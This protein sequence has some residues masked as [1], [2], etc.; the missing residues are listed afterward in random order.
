MATA[1]KRALLA[2]SLSLCSAIPSSGPERPFALDRR[3]VSSFGSQG[4]NLWMLH[5]NPLGEK[6]CGSGEQ[7]VFQGGKQ[8]PAHYFEQP[9]DHFDK[10]AN[11]TFGQ[12][13]VRLG[14]FWVNTDYYEPGGPVF[15]LDGGE[16]SG[17][18]S[19]WATS[20]TPIRRLPFL[21]TGIL[22][23]LANATKGLGIV[24][25]HR[26][27]GKSVPVN[28][29]S[30]DSLRWLN[31]AQALEDS[32]HFIANV[33]IPGLDHNVTAP[34][35]KWIYYGG[36][37]AGARAAHMR[38]LYPDLVFG[39]IAS[40]AVTHATIDYWEYADAVRRTADPVCVAHLQTAV[41]AVDDVLSTRILA[42]V[43]K[44]WFGLGGLASDQDFVS[45]LMTPVGYVQGQNWDSA[46]GSDEWSRFCVALGR[47][48]ADRILGAV[49][50]PAVVSNLARWIREA[51]RTEGI[52][53]GLTV[54]EQEI[55][56]RCPKS[57]SVEQVGLDS[58]T[59]SNATGRH[60]ISI[61]EPGSR[62]AGVDI[63]SGW[64]GCERRV[65]RRFCLGVHRVGGAP[66][67]RAYPSIVSRR[68]TLEYTS[69]ICRQAFP[70][71]AHFSV[72]AWPN[73]S[74]VNSLGDYGLAAD[75]LAFIDGDEDPWLPA[76]PHSPHAEAR[77]DTVAR[78]FKLIRTGVHHYD[79][80]G[81]ASEPENIQEIHQEETEFVPG[82]PYVFKRPA[83]R[84]FDEHPS[85]SPQYISTLA[86]DAATLS[87]AQDAS[88]P[89][90]KRGRKRNDNL[91]PNRARDV[92]RAFRARRTAHLQELE[93]RVEVLET[94]NY[95][96]RQMLSLPP[97]D[98]QP[99]GRGPTGRDPGKLLPKLAPND[100]PPEHYS[101]RST[102]S[103]PASSVSHHPGWAGLQAANWTPGGEHYMPNIGDDQVSRT[104]SG[105]SSP[106]P[107]AVNYDYANG[108]HPL[109]HRSDSL[110]LPPSAASPGF[111]NGGATPRD[112]M[113]GFPS[114]S[115]FASP[116]PSGVNPSLP[117]HSH[118][119]ATLLL[120][121]LPASNRIV[122][123]FLSS[124]A[125]SPTYLSRRSVNDLGAGF[126][127]RSNSLGSVGINGPGYGSGPSGG[128]LQLSSPSPIN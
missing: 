116:A 34:E 65:L 81:A 33:K 86:S 17:E 78:P 52:D 109:P 22:S 113:L 115:G 61:N 120:N 23:I 43:L 122:P 124:G 42:P 12:R 5:N 127:P 107:H 82:A 100:S 128:R 112:G 57:Q 58:G 121:P 104:S 84:P 117:P 69:A 75:R 66:P 103:P 53:L 51:R 98:R 36:S 29:L 111:G 87:P 105:S 94:E 68:L 18:D 63:P 4:I 19:L 50:V 7:R 89:A 16:T 25:E 35:T 10:S 27:Y 73:V 11:K 92:Q 9:L 70:A 79:E 125:G 62:M 13:R 118:S 123:N 93:H 77:V 83:S 20:D 90:S 46:V 126:P 56:S 119:N 38:V 14:R 91:P 41:Q 48:G 39:A 3:L 67:S 44:S 45:V 110:M 85:I 108:R 31:N 80:N 102:P 99:L 47:G 97:S 60:K 6:K 28:D 40:S 21:Q 76:T 54:L 59:I 8:Y 72:P 71:G 15:V 74:V 37:Y 1:F 24:L 26:Y 32:A 106:Y 2:Y 49:R 30:T 96:L 114:N 95:R 64:A 88:V 101:D 55:V